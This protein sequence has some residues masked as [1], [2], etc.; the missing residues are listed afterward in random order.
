MLSVRAAFITRPGLMLPDLTIIQQAPVEVGKE[1]VKEA[2]QVGT[3]T[4]ASV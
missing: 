2:L 4:P 3:R 1:V